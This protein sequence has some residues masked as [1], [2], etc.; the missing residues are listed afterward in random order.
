MQCAKGGPYELF[1]R[2]LIQ[3]VFSCPCCCMLLL[4]ALAAGLA[5]GLEAI[6]ETK[7]DK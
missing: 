6:I 7:Q 2:L 3:R 5:A 4:A 1:K